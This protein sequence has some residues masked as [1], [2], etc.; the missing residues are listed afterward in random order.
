MTHDVLAAYPLQADGEAGL[1]EPRHLTKVKVLVDSMIP[2]DYL[3]T[4]ADQL[5]RK[6]FRTAV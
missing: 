3:L 2:V 5:A 1:Y 4:G 6:H